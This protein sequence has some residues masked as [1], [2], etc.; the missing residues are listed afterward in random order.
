MTDRPTK[1]ER[2]HALNVNYPP[3]TRYCRCKQGRQGNCACE[4]E[5]QP[6]HRLWVPFWFAV[7]LACGALAL[8]VAGVV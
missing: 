3:D 4:R 7:A 2:H 5:P 6:E 1:Y 8:S